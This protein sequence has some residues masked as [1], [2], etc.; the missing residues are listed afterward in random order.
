MGKSVDLQD[1]FLNISD[2]IEFTLPCA[3]RTYAD[4][5]KKKDLLIQHND[6]KE[7][8]I[9][10]NLGPLKIKNTLLKN[11]NR[12]CFP[13]KEK[14]GI[15]KLSK[16]IQREMD[17]YKKKPISIFSSEKK[18]IYNPESDKLLHRIKYKDEMVTIPDMGN[19]QVYSNDESSKATKIAQRMHNFIV[20]KNV[21]E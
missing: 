1:T 6:E 19:I 7:E 8:P 21:L 3:E 18:V 12:I 11:E 4:F 13:G 2:D 16:K 14:E 9:S 17:S 5:D 10:L 20:N 15:E